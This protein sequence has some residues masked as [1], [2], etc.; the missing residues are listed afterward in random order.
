MSISRGCTLQ[1]ND[2]S[3]IEYF[4][5]AAS[6]DG[7]CDYYRLRLR[8]QYS[9]LFDWGESTGLLNE[10]TRSRYDRKSR[11]NRMV[12]VAI[13]TH[14]EHFLGELRQTALKFEGIT[15]E[16]LAVVRESQA[17]PSL[18]VADGTVITRPMTSLEALGDTQLDEED[19]ELY[20]KLF[21]LQTES[22]TIRKH[23]KGFS[24][25]L[26]VWKDVKAVARQPVRISWAISDRTKFAEKLDRVQAL[27]DH[28]HYTLSEDR[29]LALLESQHHTQLG[30]VTVTSGVEELK[31]LLQTIQRSLPAAVETQSLDSTTLGRNTVSVPTGDGALLEPGDDSDAQFKTFLERL[32]RF[33]IL[34]AGSAE[35]QSGVE[36]SA[37]ERET[38]STKRGRWVEWKTYHPTM[39]GTSPRNMQKGPDGATTANVKQ[40]AAILQI[41]DRPIEFRV[42]S[43]LGYFLDRPNDRFVFVFE[44][45]STNTTHDA[46]R[47]LLSLLA[48]DSAGLMKRVQVAL[49]MCECLSLFHTV[50]WLHKGLRSANILFFAKGEDKLAQVYI[51]GFEF[52]RP[53]TSATTTGPPHDLEW[54]PYIHPEYLDLSENGGFK[55]TYDIY[56]LGII[57]IELAY[58]KP[59]GEIMGL[60]RAASQISLHEIIKFRDRIRN[61]DKA[62]MSNLEDMMGVRYRKAVS[63]CIEGMA[64]FELGEEQDQDDPEVARLLQ[65]EFISV[66]IGHLRSIC[67]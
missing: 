51:S 39:E 24:H 14:L 66:V 16:E 4:Q 26:D 55:R 18:R 57:L 42:P 17:A 41:Q 67:I 30:M 21:S 13:L 9:R 36:I 23:W 60:S 7:D 48:G 32:I 37:A 1:A 52:S 49:Q 15:A 5:L 11:Q 25:V 33:K 35:Q 31:V 46:P 64:A 19:L 44:H 10:A 62:V 6:A 58:W 53:V 3:G 59:I 28:L 43:C 61:D 40:L 63:A 29:M 8:F 22:K 47:T 50:D 12:A 27:V 2:S 20:Q 54:A 45:P 56:S 34:A 65:Q 38:S